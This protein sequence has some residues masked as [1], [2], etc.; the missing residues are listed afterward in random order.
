VR[1][2]AFWYNSRHSFVQENVQ[3]RTRDYSRIRQSTLRLKEKINR[4]FWGDLMLQGLLAYT[5]ALDHID[6]Q[7]LFFELWTTL[8]VITLTESARRSEKLIDRASFLFDNRAL[9]RQEEFICPSSYR[10]SRP[11]VIAH[12]IEGI[13]GSFNAPAHWQSTST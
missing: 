5:R 2:N 11:G 10:A 7:T 8:E 12:A 6:W 9:A 4:S 13:C 1:P 3:S